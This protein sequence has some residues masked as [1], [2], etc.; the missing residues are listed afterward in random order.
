MGGGDR[1]DGGRAAGRTA[2]DGGHRSQAA[3]VPGEG[4][5]SGNTMCCCGCSLARAHDACTRKKRAGQEQQ[6]APIAPIAPKPTVPHQVPPGPAEQGQGPPASAS[7]AYP[8]LPV[9]RGALC[10]PGPQCRCGRCLCRRGC[11]CGPTQAPRLYAGGRAQCMRA[12]GLQAGHTG[13][14]R[15][16][17]RG[18]EGGGKGV[19]D[20]VMHAG[21][22]PDPQ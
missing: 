4:G 2:A 15:P 22:G 7:A 5:V 19:G 21:A 10:L 9:P 17:G 12:C 20:R 6:H 18:T 16:V 11:G 1:A 3:A 8:T 14:C 13:Q